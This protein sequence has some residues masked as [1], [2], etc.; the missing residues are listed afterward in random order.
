MAADD[1]SHPTPSGSRWEPPAD[2]T[3]T[4]ADQPAAAQPGPDDATTAYPTAPATATAPEAA[5]QSEPSRTPLRERRMIGIPVASAVAAGL[6]VA[7]GLGGYALGSFASGDDLTPV[8]SDDASSQ[9]GQLPGD[10]S[11]DHDGDG[12]GF[13]VGPGVLPPGFDGDADQG[14]PPDLDGDDSTGGG[15]DDGADEGAGATT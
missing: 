9:H 4:P 8:V 11:F 6:V 7:S 13:P 2:G 10:G 1:Q 15:T 14:V 5:A 3:G 12:H